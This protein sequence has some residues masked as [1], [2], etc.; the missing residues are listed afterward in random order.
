MTPFQALYGYVPPRL[1]ELVQGDAKVPG[2][3]SQHE[4]NQRI[5]QV[6]KDNLTM[7]QNHM[8]QQ[9]DIHRKEQYFEVAD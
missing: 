8:K 7:A 4:E 1:K 2:V 6:L 3:K 9:V 5:M